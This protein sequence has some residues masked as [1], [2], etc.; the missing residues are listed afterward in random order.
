M[1]QQTSPDTSNRSARL[2]IY[3][4]IIGVLLA[5]LALTVV[6]PAQADTFNIVDGDVS[7]LITAI[8]TANG[9]TAPDTIT[10]AAGGTYTLTV[11]DNSTDGPNGLPSILADGGNSLTINGNGAT[12]QRSSAVGTPRFRIFHVANGAVLTL[13]DLTVSN[14]HS[15][16]GAAG[17]DGDD[18]GGIY[19]LGALD[20]SYCTLSGNSAGHGGSCSS[21]FGG[22]GGRGGGIYSDSGTLS[23][24]HC[25]LSGNSAGDG[26]DSSDSGAGDGGDGG[27]IYEGAPGSLSLS[28]CTLTGNSAGDGGDGSGT[29]GYGG[30]GGDGGGIRSA[31]IA[32]TLSDCTLSNNSAGDGGVGPVSDEIGGSGGGIYGRV[33]TLEITNSTFSGNSSG[34]GVD[35]S[36]GGYGGGMLISGG[37]VI[38][39]TTLSGN[40][41]HQHAGGIS[42]GGS[43]TLYLSNVTVSGNTAPRAAGGVYYNGSGTVVLTNCTI[44]DNTADSDNDGDG[45]GGGIYRSSGGV[46]LENTILAGNHDS[47]SAPDC[48]G[49]ITSGEYN[50]VGDNSGCTFTPDA[51]DQV[52]TGASPINP[53]L[54]PLADN[55]GDT[56]THALLAGSPAIDAIPEGVDY[57]EAP[58]TDQRGVSRPQPAGGNCDIGAYELEGSIQVCKDVVPDDDSLWDFALSGAYSAAITGLGDDECQSF[59]ALA[60]GTYTVTEAFDASYGTE[61]SCDLGK[62]SDTDGDI[63]F[64]LAPGEDVT[65]TFTNTKTGSIEVCKDVEPS[66]DSTWDFDLSGAAS[67]SIY[68][69]RDAECDIFYDLPPGS[70]T[71]EEIGE[72]TALKLTGAAQAGHDAGIEEV[73]FGYDTTVDCGSAGTASGT[74]ITFDLAAGD[75]VECAFTNT[76]NAYI[77]VCKDVVPDDATVWDFTLS[78]ES[79][80]TISDLSD[81]QCERFTSLPPGSYT[82]SEVTQ[83]GYGTT[84][85]CGGWGSDS[86]GDITFDL[87]LGEQVYCTFTNTKHAHIDVCKDVVPYDAS[88]WDFDLSGAAT[89]AISGLGDGGCDRF[90]GLASGTYTVTEAVQSDYGT[91]V[92]CGGW[93][94]ETDGDISFAI[95][96]S[97]IVTCAFTNTKLGSIEVCKDQVPDGSKLWE[98]DI[99]GGFSGSGDLRDGECHTF[100]DLE[101]A[102]YTLEEVYSSDYDAAVACDLGKG[103]DDDRNITF[104]LAARED[105]TCTFTNTKYASIRVC[106]DVVPDDSSRWDFALSGAAS[107]SMTNRPDGSCLTFEDLPPGAYTLEE[108]GESTALMLAAAA[109]AG[110]ES[111]IVVRYDT[112]VDCGAWGSDT[113]RSI[114]LTLA[115]GDQPVCTFTNTN[116]A[117]IEVCKDV[118]PDDGS[119][120]DFTLSGPASGTIDQLAD[121]QCERFTS[122]PP[123]SYTLTE[124][125][126]AGYG[127]TVDC[128]VWG[129]DSD[130]DITFDI[131]AGDQVTCTFTN[132][133]DAYIEVCKDVVPNDTI[134]WD[135]SLSGQS[136]GTISQL[137]DS[138]CE[139]FTSLPPGSYTVSET[140]Q[141]GYDT[142]VD[143][144]SWGSDSDGDITFS[145]VAGDQ[146]TCNFTNTDDAFIGCTDNSQCISPPNTQCWA[147]PGQCDT[148][149]GECQY[150]QQPSHTP[151]DDGDPATTVDVCNDSGACVEGATLTVQLLGGGTGTVQSVQPA[152]PWDIDCGSDCDEVYPVSTAVTLTAVADT[153]SYFAGWGGDCPNLIIVGPGPVNGNTTE[154][155]INGNTIE[156]TMDSDKTCQATFD[157]LG[158]IIIEKQSTSGA[159]TGFTFQHL[160]PCVCPPPSFPI[161][162]CIMLPPFPV[163][164]G[165]PMTLT[166]QSVGAHTVMEFDLATTHPGWT[167]TDIQCDDDGSTTPSVED[168]AN[169]LAMVNLDPG[170]TV[171]CVFTNSPPSGTIIVEK[172]TDPDGAAGTFTFSGDAAG[173]I[174][175]GGQIV[176]SDLVPGTYTATEADPGPGF[177]LTDITCDDTNS[178]A[179]AS[180]GDLGTRTATF[181]LEADETVKCTFTN[182]KRSLQVSKVMVL[183]LGGPAAVDQILRF[184]IDIT[185]DGGLTIDP[186]TLRDE[187]PWECMRFR[188]AYDENGDPLPP[189]AHG[190]MAGFLQWNDLGALHPGETKMLSVEFNAWAACEEATNTATVTGWGL[191]FEDEATLRI[192]DTIARFGGRVYHD[193]NHNGGLDTP[194]IGTDVDPAGCEP[195]VEGAEALL[196]T[197]AARAL[198]GAADLSYVTNTSGWFSFN[199]LEPGDYSIAVSPPA[200]SWWTPTS[201][202]ECWRTIVNEWDEVHCDVGYR[203][204]REFDGLSATAAAATSAA[205]AVVADTMVL[206]PLQDTTLSGWDIGNHGGGDY[207]EVRQPGIA[208]AAVQFDLSQ[209]PDGAVIV[210]ARLRLYSPSAS[211][212]TN[213]LYMTAYPLDRTWVED[214]ATWWQADAATFWDEAGAEGNTGDP[215]GWGW[216][217]APSSPGAPGWVEL[218]LDPTTLLDSA[219]LLDSAYG[220][221][222]RG[223]GTWNREVAYSFFS[224]EYGNPGVHPQLVVEYHAP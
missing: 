179:G 165:V 134:L 204:G 24:S 116:T 48:W 18:G 223:E 41:S 175:D 43:G 217:G 33:D 22:Y 72:D 117:Y 12:I 93:G 92:D 178:G 145:V 144:G 69:L 42:Y 147:V 49:T 213:R 91:S 216:I 203:W 121:A 181:N 11:V 118:V 74:S 151:C 73:G 84:V 168:V 89:G 131:V 85:D 104:D 154:L 192:L 82:V 3:L 196:S 188:R 207:L 26:G 99:R 109:G 77:E 132:T 64:D 189:D 224:R 177:G 119:L 46:I 191:T 88:T 32:L 45:D 56:Q 194:C 62:G 6:P 30:P 164:H 61:V 97:E 55:G 14:G 184:D 8:N 50:I 197:V 90:E 95:A 198:S 221:L 185:N 81:G 195:G 129:S 139:R 137:G 123:G 37:G 51:S 96:A 135:F 170:E 68:E 47:S 128:G 190:G 15:P 71:V 60:G 34:A 83:A 133:N 155:T 21:C 201:D 44:T 193:D 210:S 27:G 212:D 180:A 70:Y 215:V 174:S 23:L 35:A 28:Q 209:L 124:T 148:N 115:A 13:N 153:G 17:S 111:S 78:G 9:N 125:V 36:E 222:I 141:S 150:D 100:T 138:L 2:S 39:N 19:N 52:G 142:T 136:S 160:P 86:D 101:P 173:T 103:S 140:V 169:S 171:T 1:K 126:Q 114:D 182:A 57:N 186:L 107:G 76:N 65:C 98:I 130:G 120:W 167:L 220:F 159:G 40:I 127:A 112:T 205:T 122:V 161:C 10:L 5:A 176:V 143:C 54:G 158:T 87:D 208:S 75:D 110:Q 202:E 172:Q 214:E 146:V 66:D 79:S 149:T 67:D 80:G 53:L 200:G 20:L 7:G 206:T 59:G 113:D 162:L 16:D 105:V 152:P 25:F 156:L 4:L 199:L 63:T 157:L 219:A 163:D 31:N 183:P 211:N 29:D 166:N 108:V 58:P 94:S 102:S 187:Y 106:K 38:S 218:E